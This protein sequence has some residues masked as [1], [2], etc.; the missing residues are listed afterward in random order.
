MEWRLVPGW[1]AYRVNREGVVQSCFG[2]HGNLTD[3]W[4][5]LVG[6]AGEYGHRR[7]RMHDGKGH[8][9]RA[10]VHIVVLETFVGPRPDGAEACHNDGNPLNNSL[11]NLR[12]DTH[13]GN[14]QDCVRH[15]R[16]LAGTKNP[17]AKLTPEQVA[18]IKKRRASG[19]ICRTIAADFG[20]CL[21]TVWLIGLGRIWRNVQEAA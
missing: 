19:E 7:I 9:V 18:Q 15:G 17:K 12:W 14:M 8:R 13:T 10:R 6:Y 11:E 1:P 16:T 21:D 2:K 4:R 3:T 20:V 5:T